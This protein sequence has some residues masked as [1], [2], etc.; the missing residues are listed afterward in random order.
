M[1]QTKCMIVEDNPADMEL[2]MYYVNK[3]QS[4]QLTHS[5][6]NG[7]E[8]MPMI[9]QVRPPLFFMDID[10]PVIN[11]IDL[12]KNL[13]YSPLC[14]FVTAH[15]EYA[16]DSYE[17]QAFDFILKPVTGKRFEQTISRLNEYLLLRERADLYD[18][19]FEKESI[20]IKEGTINYRVP[21]N[22]ILYIEAL[23]DYSKVITPKKKYTTLSK[24]KHFMDKLPPENFLRIHRSYAIAKNKITTYNRDEVTIDKEILPIGKTYRQEARMALDN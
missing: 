4:L 3:E 24:L 7:L 6:L 20:T 9:K 2:L 5:F 12:F 13:D 19:A 1:S 11:G 14:I 21:L 17:A 16:L 22:D 10:M 18:A 23:K 8:A 15:S